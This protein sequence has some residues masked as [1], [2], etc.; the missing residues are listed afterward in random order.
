MFMSFNDIV[1]GCRNLSDLLYKFDIYNISILD[2][3]IFIDES[4]EPLQINDISDCEPYLSCALMYA[5]DEATFDG[6]TYK[7]KIRIF[8]IRDGSV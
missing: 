4:D 3:E 2:F 7:N 1:Y 6:I 5:V 8:S